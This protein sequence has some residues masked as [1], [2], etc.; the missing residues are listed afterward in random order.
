MSFLISTV[1]KIIPLSIKSHPSQALLSVAAALPP[2]PSVHS[3]PPELAADYADDEIQ[4][5]AKNRSI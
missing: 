1:P 5:I 3:L 2:L 4:K